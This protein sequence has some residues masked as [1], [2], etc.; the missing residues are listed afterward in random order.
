MKILTNDIKTAFNS[1]RQSYDPSLGLSPL[2]IAE[3]NTPAKTHVVAFEIYFDDEEIAAVSINCYDYSKLKLKPEA[4]F[5]WISA[6]IPTSQRPF[7]SDD[8]YGVWRVQ[9]PLDHV[10]VSSELTQVFISRVSGLLNDIDSLLKSKVLSTDWIGDIIPSEVVFEDY[11]VKLDPYL[12]KI[13]DAF[14]SQTFSQSSFSTLEAEKFFKKNFSREYQDE[15]TNVV[16]E[17]SEQAYR[18]V[19]LEEPSYRWGLNELRLNFNFYDGSKK[20][21]SHYDLE[22]DNEE[23]ATLLQS[24]ANAQGYILTHMNE[25]KRLL[26]TPL[27]VHLNE[28]QKKE[29]SL[30]SYYHSINASMK[31]SAVK[32][33]FPQNAMGAVLLPYSRA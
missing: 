30:L 6:G 28:L 18:V 33:M 29:D 5:E 10:W 1:T 23:F 8:C 4:G 9:M 11:S 13:A 19:L 14:F 7:T 21:Y 16:D 20:L 24:K 25:A 22:F 17:N 27:L 3:T 12:G 15:L 31:V 2:F 32:A 26:I